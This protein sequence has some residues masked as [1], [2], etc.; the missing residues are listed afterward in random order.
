V[1]LQDKTQAVD[2]KKSVL[3]GR[4]YFKKGENIE[5]VG[6]DERD[7]KLLYSFVSEPAKPA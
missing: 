7:I 2:Y 4:V 5:F 3:E 6:T 1:A